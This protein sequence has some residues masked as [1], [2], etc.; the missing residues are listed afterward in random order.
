MGRDLAQG[1]QL[2][3]GTEEITLEKTLNVGLLACCSS[4]PQCKSAK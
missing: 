1:L 2:M 4:A 3:E